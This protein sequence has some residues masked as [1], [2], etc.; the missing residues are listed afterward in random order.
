MLNKKKGSYDVFG[1]LLVTM[2]IA[3]GIYI[4]GGVI[5]ERK[6]DKKENEYVNQKVEK[7]EG[8]RECN[9][10]EILNSWKELEGEIYVDD[11]GVM[12]KFIQVLYGGREIEN[13]TIDM[14]EAE[15]I[16]TIYKCSYSSGGDSKEFNIVI[17]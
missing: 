16:S 5:V 13:V 10:E 15:E 6:L 4:I 1:G 17:K 12:N 3:V 7:I 11:L 8:M 14:I 2:V 9:A